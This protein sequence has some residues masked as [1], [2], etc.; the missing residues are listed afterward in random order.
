MIVRIF[1]KDV[2]VRTLIFVVGEG[3]LIYASVLIAALLRSSSPHTS[4]LSDQILGKAALITVVCQAC[5]YYNELYNLKVTDTYLELGLR[6]TKAIGIASIVLALL[7]YAIPSLMM[8]RGIFFI[9]L[10]FVVLLVVPWRY[11]YNW[12][13]R[14]KMFAEKVMIMGH[15]NLYREIIH[16]INSRPDSGYQIAGVVST[17]SISASNPP[18]DIP[19]FNM[20][21]APLVPT[22]TGTLYF[23][24]SGMAFSSQPLV[25][26]RSSKG[27][28][29]AP[30]CT[31]IL[32]SNRGYIALLT[33]SL[34]SRAKKRSSLCRG[35]SL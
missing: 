24:K 16:E 5:L 18:R 33:G 9:S 35:H 25:S 21:A 4:F 19:V 26:S 28:P 6:L 14:K 7:Y 34:R 15:G 30:S 32:A 17:N 12:V 2:P 27:S 3:F 10:L 11:A 13:L 20:A 31:G 29:K 8:G 1:N 23:M 22:L